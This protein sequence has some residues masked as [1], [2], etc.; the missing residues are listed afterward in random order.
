LKYRSFDLAAVT[1]VIGQGARHLAVFIRAPQNAA[2]IC[3]LPKRC[4]EIE[5]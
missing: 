1:R 4:F 3:K 2:L 5:V